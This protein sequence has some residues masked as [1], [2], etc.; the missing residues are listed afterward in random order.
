MDE[1]ELERE[2]GVEMTGTGRFGDP[3]AMTIDDILLHKLYKRPKI[4]CC[5]VRIIF[6]NIDNVLWKVLY[7]GVKV[8]CVLCIG[9]VN[10]LKFI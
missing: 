5:G 3:S 6:K 9:R 10:S 1:E 7:E 2:I 8:P 4:V